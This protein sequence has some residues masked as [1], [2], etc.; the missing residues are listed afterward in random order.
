MIEEFAWFLCWLAIFHAVHYQFKVCIPV[1]L[2]CLKFIESIL[3]LFLLKLFVFYQLHG[4]GMDVKDMVWE[5]YN[6][7]KVHVNKWEL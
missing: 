6:Y 1:T 3:L 4:D 2:F 5:L 7:T